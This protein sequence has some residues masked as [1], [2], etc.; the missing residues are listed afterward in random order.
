MSQKPVVKRIL[1][2]EM[3]K[4]KFVFCGLMM[5]RYWRYDIML[6]KMMLLFSLVMIRYLPITSG[7]ADIIFEEI[8]ISVS[9][10]I[11]QRQTSLKKALTI[12]SAFFWCRW[13]E[14]NRHGIA[15]GGFW[16]RYVC[17]FHH[18]GVY[19]IYYQNIIAHFH[20]YVNSFLNKK[21]NSLNW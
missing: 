13:P 2:N 9:I 10:I 4:S 14:S 20:S 6:R 16:V 19:K 11:C 8:I 1:V 17:Q 18:S 15:T 12:A 3:S 5:Y 7:E 21:T